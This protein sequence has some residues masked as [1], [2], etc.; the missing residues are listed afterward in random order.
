MISVIGAG[1]VGAY[2]AYLLAKAGEKVRIFEEHKEIG[3]PVQCA[4]IVSKNLAKIIKIDDKFVVNKVKGARI[5]SPNNE[6]FEVKGSEIEGFVLD[7]EKFDR[8]WVEKAVDGG[9]E[10]FLNHRFIE[11]NENELKFEKR[12]YKTDILIGADGPLSRVAECNNMLNRRFWSGL[13]A[14]IKLE[15]DKEFV[16]LYMGDH[17]KDGYGWVVPEGN[18]ICRVGVGTTDKNIV[19]VFNNFLKRF[20]KKIINKQSGLIPIYDPKIKIQRGNVY[21]VGDAAGQTKATTGGGIVVGMSASKILSDCLLNNKN[22]EKEFKKKLGRNMRMNLII[23]RSLN[24][25]NDNKYNELI[26]MF[27]KDKVKA[28]MCKRGDMDF[29]SRFFLGLLFKE[30]RLLKFLF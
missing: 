22:Y 20:N 7:R 24:K 6:F 1:P 30:P 4:G 10:L 28:H 16:E 18:G 23:R 11:N 14:R 27:N 12:N 21:L 26:K 9:A 3:K 2:T 29:P 8:Y 5:Y 15:K 17:C 13:Q 25:F 19:E